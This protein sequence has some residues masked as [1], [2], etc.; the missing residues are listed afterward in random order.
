MDCLAKQ[1]TVYGFQARTFL[2][3]LLTADLPSVASTATKDAYSVPFRVTKGIKLA[4]FQYKVI[5]NMLCTK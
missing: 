1:S 4:I 2:P 5:H 3:Q